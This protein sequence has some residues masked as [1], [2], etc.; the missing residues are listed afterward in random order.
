M[1]ICIKS[2]KQMC[3]ILQLFKG[4]LPKYAYVYKKLPNLV[5]NKYTNMYIGKIMKICLYRSKAQNKCVS[6]SQ[7]LRENYPNML[8]CI[9][10]YQT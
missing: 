7:L 3:F 4:K 6:F 8:M 1:L 10:N 2:S 5:I 9:K